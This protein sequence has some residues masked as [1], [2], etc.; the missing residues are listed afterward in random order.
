MQGIA[1][2]FACHARQISNESVRILLTKA[3]IRGSPLVATPPNSYFSTHTVATI[4]RRTR[5]VLHRKSAHL[6]YGS[7][8][9]SPRIFSK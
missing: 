1:A 7:M 4:G 9:G 6:A 8:T 5:P 2:R 3:L